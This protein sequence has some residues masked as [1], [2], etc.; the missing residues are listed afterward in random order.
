[1]MA[2]VS[3]VPVAGSPLVGSAARRI[4]GPAAAWPSVGGTGIALP[5]CSCRR[6][7]S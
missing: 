2:R 3:F 4:T 6:I 1:M 5:N 7:P